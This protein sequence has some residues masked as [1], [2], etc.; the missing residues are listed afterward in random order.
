[1]HHYTPSANHH[2]TQRDTGKPMENRD[3][4]KWKLLAEAETEQNETL[5]RMPNTFFFCMPPIFFTIA[6]RQNVLFTVLSCFKNK[7]NLQIF[8]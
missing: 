7:N 6:N 2:K 1:M 4:Q 3:A 5:G 8:T